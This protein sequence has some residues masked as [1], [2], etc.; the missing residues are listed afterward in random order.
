[1]VWPILLSKVASLGWCLEKTYGVRDPYLFFMKV[2]SWAS[3]SNDILP[4]RKFCLP[5][6]KCRFIKRTV[7]K[8]CNWNIYFFISAVPIHGR[9]GYREGGGACTFHG[10]QKG[11]ITV[12]KT[13]CSHFM[14][15]TE[16]KHSQV[17]RFYFVFSLVMKVLAGGNG[18]P[19]KY[20]HILFRSADQQSRFARTQ[21]VRE[22]SSANYK[23][24]KSAIILWK[25]TTSSKMVHNIVTSLQTKVACYSP[26]SKRMKW[27]RSD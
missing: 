6:Q 3:V 18:T 20:C 13:P 10:H 9:V 8:L 25:K 4:L 22:I 17:H 5:L 2:I 23:K 27:T 19:C 24:I 12:I 26:L 11:E 15:I 14:E 16:Q 7:I 1:M 21:F